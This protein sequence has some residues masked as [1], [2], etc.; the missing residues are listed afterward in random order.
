MM[1]LVFPE[2]KCCIEF[3]VD[4]WK[5]TLFFSSR[6]FAKVVMFKN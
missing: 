5:Q 4:V 2:K 3:I 6:R 1:G